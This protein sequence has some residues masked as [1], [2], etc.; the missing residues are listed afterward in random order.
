MSDDGFSCNIWLRNGIVAK[1]QAAD[2][3][4]GGCWSMPSMVLDDGVKIGERR[5]GKQMLMWA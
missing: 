3:C 2:V 1:T 4:F 5:H